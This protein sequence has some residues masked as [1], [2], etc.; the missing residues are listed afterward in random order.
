MPKPIRIFHC[1]D[2]AAFTRLVRHWLA[3]HAEFEHVGA[4]HSGDDALR[5]L[6]AARPDVVLLDTMGAPGETSL[7]AA[8]RVT[9]PH[10]RVV[11]YSGYLSILDPDQLGGEADGYLEKADDEHALVATIHAVI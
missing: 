2:S 6:T 4:A 7:L 5:A 3:E 11:V 1:D 10:A 8:I 9:V